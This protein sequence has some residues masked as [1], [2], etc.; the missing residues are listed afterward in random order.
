MPTPELMPTFATAV[1][2]W[3]CDENDH[4]NVQ[5][6]TEFAHDASMH[7]LA[8]LG[9][10][11]RAQRTQDLGVRPVEDHVR[12]LREFRP[13]DPVEVRSAPVEIGERHL[14]AYHEIRNPADGTLAATVRCRL[15]CDRPWPDAFRACADAASVAL[16]AVARA[17]SVG[18]TALPLLTLA[19]ARRL[20]L[21]QASRTVIKPEECDGEGGLLPRCLF[22]RYSD[23]AP[24]L[25]NHLGFDRSAMQERQ[26]GTVVLET[27]QHYRSPLRTADLALVMS[28]LVDF[29]EKTLKLVHYAFE[30]ET[31]TLAACAEGIGVKFDQKARKIMS[32]SDEDRARLAALK[33]PLFGQGA[34]HG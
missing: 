14:L 6:Y 34:R 33:V 15:A 27:L 16:P 24:M 1:N 21:I 23:A 30:A 20:G 11:P 8:A 32:F 2:T 18:G 19:E 4:L 7:L 17:R 26:E 10:G 28:G 31:G 22:G 5:F 9:L 25:W 12:Y 29:T 13:V 3:Q